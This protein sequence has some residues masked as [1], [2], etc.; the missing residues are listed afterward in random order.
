[1]HTCIQYACTI[2]MFIYSRFKEKILPKEDLE[3]EV[4]ELEKCIESLGYPV[5]FSHNDLLL[6]NII[7]NKEK[8]MGFSCFCNFS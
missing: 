8:G 1:M 5:V 7:Y 2:N 4:L 3:K 6:K